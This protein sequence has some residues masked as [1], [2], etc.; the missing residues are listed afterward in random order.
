MLVPTAACTVPAAVLPADPP[1]AP[2]EPAVPETTPPSLSPAPESITAPSLSRDAVRD[3]AAILPGWLETVRH[4]HRMT[5][6]AA[7]AA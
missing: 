7:P 1:A 2:K 5:G 6:A 4:L 3:V